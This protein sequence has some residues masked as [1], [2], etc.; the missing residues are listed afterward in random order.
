VSEMNIEK[1]LESLRHEVREID[2]ELV[3][4]LVKRVEVAKKIGQIKKRNSLPI[5][6]PQREAFNN[7]RNRELARGS[8]PEPMI[9]ELTDFLANWAREIQKMVR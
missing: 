7:D 9:D 5:F 1:D 3:G 8:L 4:L 2:D 6:D